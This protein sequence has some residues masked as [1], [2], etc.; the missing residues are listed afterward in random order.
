L[1]KH[2]NEHT[3]SRSPTFFAETDDVNT[4]VGLAAPFDQF[5]SSMAFT[6]EPGNQVTHLSPGFPAAAL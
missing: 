3:L 6:G 1:K 2:A 5:F 4:Y